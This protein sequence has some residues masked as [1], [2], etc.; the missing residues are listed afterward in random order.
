MNLLDE[1]IRLC[2][3]DKRN[4]SDEE[5]DTYQKH[6]QQLIY[7]PNLLHLRPLG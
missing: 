7:Y 5:R 1:H 3:R 2:G 4:E 6:L